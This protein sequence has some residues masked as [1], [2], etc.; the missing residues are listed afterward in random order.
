MNIYQ[1]LNEVRKSV[2]YLKKDKDVNKRYMAVTHDFVTASLREHLIKHGIM[3][4]PSVVSSVVAAT[5]IT[6]SKGIP[7]I[8]YEARYDVR[9]VNCDDPTD[10]VTMAVEAHAMDEGDKAPGKGVSYATKNAMLKMFSIETGEDDEGRIPQ[11]MPEEALAEHL[12]AIE[13]TTTEAAL[14]KAYAAAYRAA[15]GDKHAMEIIIKAKDARKAELAK[16]AA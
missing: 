2:A 7:F 8:R 1:R 16:V 9:F 12:S 13:S 4:I 3:I 10:F 6:T 5:G 15:N 11:G 14:K